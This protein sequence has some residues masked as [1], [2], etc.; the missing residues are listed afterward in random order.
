MDILLVDD[1]EDFLV[2]VKQ[3]LDQNGYTVHTAKDGMEGCE[4]SRI[5]TST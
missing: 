5:P 1:N 4:F 3:V 2:L